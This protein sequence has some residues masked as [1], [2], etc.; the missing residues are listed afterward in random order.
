MLDKFHMDDEVARQTAELLFD[1]LPY[2]GSGEND[3]ADQ[4]FLETLN[5]NETLVNCVDLHANTLLMVAAQ[6]SKLQLI[7]IFL[8]KHV[9][10]N[11]QNY[12]G[13]S[14][15]H[16]V[17]YETNQNSYPM[18]EKLIRAGADLKSSDTEG[19]TP[20]HYA[21]SAGDSKIVALLLMYGSDPLTKDKRGFVPQDY[22]VQQGHKRVVDL[23]YNATASSHPDEAAKPAT[24]SSSQAAQSD[25]AAAET[26]RKVEKAAAGLWQEFIDPASNCPYYYNALT[27]ETTWERPSDFAPDANSAAMEM[28]R[29]SS[30]RQ[31]ESKGVDDVVVLLAKFKQIA[32][33][34]GMRKVVDKQ[35]AQARRFAMEQAK[36]R[37]YLLQQGG[38]AAETVKQELGVND[39]ELEEMRSKLA[40]FQAAQTMNES[41]MTEM[42]RVLEAKSAEFSNV[43]ASMDALK[44]E[45]ASKDDEFAV[46]QT[47]AAQEVEQR[48]ARQLAD[49]RA[50]L[51]ARDE[52]L[53]RVRTQLVDTEK[54]AEEETSATRRAA[55]VAAKAQQDAAATEMEAA[56]QEMLKRESELSAVRAEA[57]RLREE[58]QSNEVEVKRARELASR[59]AQLEYEAEESKK[60]LGDLQ[61]HNEK[62]R[63][64]YLQEQTLRR[65]YHNE[66][67]DLKGA[68]RV[69]CRVRPL[70]KSELERG[71]FDCTTIDATSINLTDE[72][73][74]KTFEFD[75]CFGTNS[76]QEEV[77]EDTKRLV[78]SAMDGF[79]VCVFAYGQTGS[80]KTFTMSGVPSLPGITPRTVIELFDIQRRDAGKFRYTFTFYMMELYKD[81]LV[82]LLYTGNDDGR[83]KLNIKKDQR[84]VVYVEGT[85]VKPANSREELEGL[86]QSG[87]D[88][89][90]VAST[91]MN[92][93]SS[94]SHLIM[95]VIIDSLNLA[96]QVSTVGKLTLV[97]L[98]GSE[99]A[100]K[101]GATG[102]QMKEAQSINKSLSALG[103]VIGAL[104]SGQKHVPYRN[105]PLTMLMSDSLGGN[106]KTLMFVNASPAEYN[107]AETINALDYAKRVKTVTNVSSKTVE[108]EAIKSLK[109]ELAELKKRA[110][111][112]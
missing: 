18:A 77:F 36:A 42:R 17:C 73:T 53:G 54:K 83:P 35:K 57:Q 103:D 19:C 52:E 28:V 92:S 69:F 99:R 65:K 32:W 110:G 104:T 45:T 107:I 43:Q 75:S 80:G 74:E 8:K 78:Q 22:A 26:E 9:N 105:H 96:T 6:H 95:A 25:H 31:R 27:G 88:G 112:K 63:K 97:D 38:E 98:A 15:M 108:T 106:A 40:E 87:F 48:A 82:D 111:A 62:L 59:Q 46:N 68:I 12:M 102:E 2:F 55:A 3:Q 100:G 11:A 51:A 94:R 30:Q 20:L 89:R 50:Q 16:I 67:E 29:R 93:E 49:L 24:A 47:V 76:T 23:L 34:E 56:R 64:D 66:V 85:T 109:K 101:T 72:G 61:V 70:S 60:K 44:R 91:K 90:H 41:K 81:F 4:I 37:I 71:N 10:V 86:I 5:S 7:D 13:V 58:T 79:N 33:R 39:R 1:L 14:T 84:G 21:A